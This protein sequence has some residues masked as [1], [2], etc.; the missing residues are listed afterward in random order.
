ME[1]VHE[2]LDFYHAVHHLGQIAALRKDWSAKARTRWRTH[3]R[4]LLM[5]GEVAQVLAL[6]QSCVFEVKSRNRILESQ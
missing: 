5:R 2:L 4:R 1:Q 6:S 3:Q